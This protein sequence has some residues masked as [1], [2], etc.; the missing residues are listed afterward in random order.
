ME[1]NEESQAGF[2]HILLEALWPASSFKLVNS[3]FSEIPSKDQLE[4]DKKEKHLV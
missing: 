1:K 3:S 4:T 2:K